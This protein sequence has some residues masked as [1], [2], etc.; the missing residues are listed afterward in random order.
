ML[1]VSA[2]AFE[3][4]GFPSDG[5]LKAEHF[6][7]LRKA[8]NI[9]SI[10]R[11][12][13]AAYLRRA[14]ESGRRIRSEARRIGYAEGFSHFSAA[15]ER[16]DEARID[17]RSRLVGLL[18]QSLHRVLGGMP[19]E[20]WVSVLLEDVLR[21]L[22]GDAE[23]VIMTHPANMHALAAAIASLKRRNA[24]LVA[25]RPE[26]NAQMTED[27]CLVYAGLEV[28]DVSLPVV[29]DEMI[30]ALNVIPSGYG[31]EEQVDDAEVESANHR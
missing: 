29:V 3:A 28:I 11:K 5:I 4:D 17:L 2:T 12:K 8:E 6:A 10:A 22:R 15:V 14:R 16:L 23:I 20:E 7:R 27:E 30:A 18:R 26:A 9:E 13:A 19:R 24:S 31:G 1:K 25:I 21:E